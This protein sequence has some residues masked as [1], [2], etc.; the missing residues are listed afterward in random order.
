VRTGICA[1]CGRA[2]PLRSR[3]LCW[4][5]YNFVRM[6]GDVTQYPLMP[7]DPPAQRFQCTARF[8]GRLYCTGEVYRDGLCA[9]HYKKLGRK[10]A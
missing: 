10:A 7:R 6:Y 9:W 3:H 1:R 5:C 8:H 4:S 2:R